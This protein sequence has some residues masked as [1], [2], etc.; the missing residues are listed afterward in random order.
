M[1]GNNPEVKS[2]TTA[3]AG[4]I[5]I[6]ADASLEVT[7]D[8]TSKGLTTI[9]SSSS[10]SGTFKVTGTYDG[11]L[12][13]SRNIPNAFTS[14]YLI[15]SPV[16]NYSIVDYTTQNSLQLGSGTGTAQNIAMARY[17]NT[18]SVAV[19]RWSYYTVGET[20]HATSVA[21]T[22]DELNVGQGYSTS[23]STAG[24][25]T[26]Q[27]TINTAPYLIAL[28]Q[29]GASG[30]NFNLLGNPFATYINS[31]VFLTTNTSELTQEEIYLWNQGNG[32]YDTKVSGISFEVAPGQGFFV[33]ANSTNNVVFNQNIQI[34]EGTT[35]RFQK[36]TRPEIKLNISDSESK[37]YAQIY[38]IDGTTTGFDNGY[39]GKL[40]GGVSQPFAVYSHLVSDSK[41]DNY[42]IQSLPNS[43]HEN[44]VIPIGL[45]A[46]AGKEITFT[47]EALNLPSGIKVFLED[48]ET[49]TFTRL[50]EVNS[51][52][53]I[54]LTETTNGIGR[55][56]LHAKS[57]V[58]TTNNIALENVSIY[59]TNNETL[60]IIG[61][62]QGKS[63]VK[64]FNILGKQMM[65]TSF[66]SNGVKDINLPKL[67]TGVYVVQLENENGKLNKKIILE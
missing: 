57:S 6:D 34:H 10:N 44:M 20:D 64:L 27:G 39:D 29:G 26:F 32:S 35:D 47:A 55:F 4:N 18:Q 17:D 56:Y 5:T 48:R 63:N 7:Q 43:D 30:T 60:R 38:Y 23:L 28:T 61:L 46:V 14:F 41:G 49:N 36:T 58:L 65:N 50:D 52:Y 53:S 33:E 1:T 25:I 66:N 12:K 37:R 15:S 11:F 40:F 2:G 9:N 24:T 54:T 8:L 45:N 62:S 16:N 22:T 21:D 59:K 19:D 67:A 3:F 51:S 31:G 42:Q 13:Y